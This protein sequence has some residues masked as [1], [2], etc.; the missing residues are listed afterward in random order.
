MILSRRPGTSRQGGSFSPETIQA[1]WNKGSVVPG[2]DSRLWR[3][4]ACGAWMSRNDHGS[5]NSQYGWEID[6]IVPVSKGGGDEFSNLQPL[7][8]ENNRYKGDN[9]PNWSC[10]VRG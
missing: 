8:W 4:D 2:Y 7:F 5:T 10:K 6:H 1:V 9:N 3:K